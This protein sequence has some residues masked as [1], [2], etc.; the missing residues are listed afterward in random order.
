MSKYVIILNNIKTVIYILL[1]RFLFQIDSVHEKSYTIIQLLYFGNFL[2]LWYKPFCVILY[3]Y[4][5][6]QIL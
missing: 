6:I 5:K 1:F 3:L 4:H 2:L